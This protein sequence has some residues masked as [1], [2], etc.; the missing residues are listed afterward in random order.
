M[1]KEYIWETAEEMTR[2]LALR[3]RRIRKRR[4]LTREELSKESGVGINEIRH[5]EDTGEISL[6]YLTKLAVALGCEEE[7]RGLFTRIPYQN[8][9]EVIRDGK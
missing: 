3:M 7:I 1:A 5:F 6:L 2:Q 9:E 8:I 4:S